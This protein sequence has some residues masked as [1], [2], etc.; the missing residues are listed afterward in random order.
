MLN[1][2]L[3][4]PVIGFANNDIHMPPVIGDERMAQRREIRGWRVGDLT[5]LHRQ[6]HHRLSRLQCS[7]FYLQPDPS[8]L[9][10]LIN[11]LR[12]HRRAASVAQLQS[13]WAVGRSRRGF[14]GVDEDER[15]PARLAAV[16]YPSMVGALLHQD[17][18]GLQVHLGIV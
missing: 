15:D 5:S 14:H 18:S 16:V 3:E 11:S 9:P 1:T 2:A 17:I 10:R 4:R 8:G 7:T 12:H 13:C 6:V